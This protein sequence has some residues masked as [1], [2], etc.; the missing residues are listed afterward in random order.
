MSLTFG[1]NPYFSNFMHDKLLALAITGGAG[2]SVDNISTWAWIVRYLDGVSTL[3]GPGVD[4]YLV[5]LSVVG[6]PDLFL[7][8]K[9]L[10]RAL[11]K[12]QAAFVILYQ[13]TKLHPRSRFI[14]LELFCYLINFIIPSVF[15]R[16]ASWDSIILSVLELW[17]VFWFFIGLAHGEYWLSL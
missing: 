1:M 10:W 17:F 13:L 4:L 3:A 12:K 14:S 7:Y 5:R 15:L 16:S 11:A 9:L 2:L 6:Q 8:F